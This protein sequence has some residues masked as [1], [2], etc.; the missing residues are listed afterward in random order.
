MPE[1]SKILLRED[2]PMTVLVC[3]RI[4]KLTE[5]AQDIVS[6]KNG[7]EALDFIQNNLN[8]MPDK[9]PEVIFLDLNM[10]I[11]GGWEFLDSFTGLLPSLQIIPQVYILSSTV[12]PEDEKKGLGYPYINRFIS[13]PLTKENLDKI[14]PDHSAKLK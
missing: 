11:M 12:D 4:I 3:E 14:I 13:K 8:Q 9:L 2:D 1:F 10:P 6:V 5:F 7:Q